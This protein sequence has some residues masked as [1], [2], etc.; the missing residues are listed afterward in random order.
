MPGTLVVGGVRNVYDWVLAMKATCYCC[1]RLAKTS[2]LEGFLSQPFSSSVFGFSSCTWA[3]MV[4]H[5]A[6]YNSI[7]CSFK[8]EF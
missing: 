6:F 2:N 1:E 5:G 3:D 4:R 8:A 7:C